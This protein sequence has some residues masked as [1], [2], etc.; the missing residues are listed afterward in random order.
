MIS[1]SYTRKMTDT[2]ADSSKF[3]DLVSNTAETWAPANLAWKV[4]SMNQYYQHHLGAC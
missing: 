1:I 2:E 3:P 4:W